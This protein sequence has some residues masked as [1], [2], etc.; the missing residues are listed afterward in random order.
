MNIILLER[1][2]NLGN[3]GDEVKVR[4]GYARNF[5]LPNGK[6]I[7]ATSDNREDFKIRRDGLEKAAKDLL[8][9]ARQKAES[10]EGKSITI[11]ARAREGGKLYGS[12]GIREI[13]KELSLLGIE[14]EK[15]QIDLPA[16]GQIEIIGEY[17]IKVHLHSDVQVKIDLIVVP[18]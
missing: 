17:K 13:E 8:N 16:E 5:L 2:K 1:V 11:A 10:I 18:V 6:A 4:N 14:V 9:S 12:V 3:L 15:Q 7:Q